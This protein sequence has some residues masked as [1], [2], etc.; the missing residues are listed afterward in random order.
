MNIN[1]IKHSAA[2]GSYVN[3]SATAKTTSSQGKTD[4]VAIDAGRFSPEKYSAT[5]A[6]ELSS[7]VSSERLSSL[8]EAIEGGNY[9]IPAEML[10]DALL[11]KV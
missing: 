6:Q 5:V 1:N 3:S 4:K 8:R 7:E 2:I 10:A 11:G 9:K